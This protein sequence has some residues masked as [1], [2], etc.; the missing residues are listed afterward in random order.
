MK[1][2]HGPVDSPQMRL[3]DFKACLIWVGNGIRN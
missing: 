2:V 1:V 3:L